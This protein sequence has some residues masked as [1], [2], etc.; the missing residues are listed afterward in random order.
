MANKPRLGGILAERKNTEAL[1]NSAIQPSR[2]KQTQATYP[3][4]P[5]FRLINC[6]K[7]PIHIPRDKKYELVYF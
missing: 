4:I 1:A 2:K 7:Y 6:Y 3:N 5:A